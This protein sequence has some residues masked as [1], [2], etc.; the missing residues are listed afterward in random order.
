M[1]RPVDLPYDPATRCAERH[2][3]FERV[4]PLGWATFLDSGDPARSTGRYDVI[5]A[6]P[7]ATLIAHDA[8]AFAQVRSLLANARGSSP[9]W[10]IAGGAIG[11]FGYELGRAGAGLPRDKPGAWALMPEAAMGLYAWTVV[12]DHVERRAAITSLDSFTDGEAQAIRD[13][14]LSGEPAARE[15]FRFPSEI[16]SSLERDAYLPRAAR[17]IDYIRAGDCYQANLT[18]EFSAPYTGDPW[19][20]YRHLHDVNPAPMGAF[21][22]YPFG[23]VL[24]SSPERFVTVEGRDAITRPIKGTRR[25]RPDPEQD[26][27]ARAELLASEKDRAENV[28]IV[29]LMRNDFSRVCEKGSVATPEICKLESFATVHHL[30]STVTGRLPADRDALDLLEA[31]FPGGSIT[32]AP[33]RRAMEIIDELE[34]H[35]R[36]VY[37]GAIGYVSA[38]GR[39]DMNIPIRTTVCADGDLRFYAGGGIVADSSPENEFEETEVKIAAIRRTLSRFSGAGVPDPDKARLRKIFIEV[40]DA[41]AARTGA[42]FA[43]SITRRL[44]ALPEYHRARTVLATLSIGSEWDTRTFAEGVLADGKT[45]VLPRVVKKPRALEIFAV[46]DLAADLLP[47]VWGIEEPDPARCRK[48]TLAEVDFALV[49]ALAVDREGYRLGYGAGYFDRLLSTAAPFRVV[50]LPGEQVVDR[51]P[52]EAHDIAVDAV[53]TDETYFTTGK[54]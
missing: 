24:S 31:C 26:A 44:R 51:L 37:C 4:R 53:L 8:S 47:G 48:L 34:P 9:P 25:R 28:M 10:P 39:M 19:E 20:L 45:L 21:L 12:I 40:R 6:G 23:S 13:K 29:D 54:K 38:A 11:Y 17:V 42:A 16:V 33:K 5:A 46:G 7:V 27:Q 43:E 30:V 18:R 22:E 32:G 50:A 41:Y 35:R 15:P 36:E 1:A 14:L 3:W 49:P 52:R 2:T